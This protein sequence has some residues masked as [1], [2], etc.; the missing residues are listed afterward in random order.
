MAVAGGEPRPRPGGKLR[1]R[2]PRVKHKATPQNR[3]KRLIR[4]RFRGCDVSAS[5]ATKGHHEDTKTTKKNGS[6]PRR[7]PVS[8]VIFVS[9]W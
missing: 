7:V 2:L 6:R 3:G 5:V 8:F 9:S 1:K 4:A